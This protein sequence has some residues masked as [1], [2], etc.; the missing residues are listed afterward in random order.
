MNEIYIHLPSDVQP[1]R[2]PSNHASHYST[3]LD[4][5]I[6]LVGEW[7]VA[8]AEATYPKNVTMFQE[9]GIKFVELYKPSKCITGGKV[10]KKRVNIEGTVQNLCSLISELAPLLLTLSYE[11]D[12]FK[13]EVHHDYYLIH[14]PQR[15]QNLLGFPTCDFIK[16]TYYSKKFEGEG[17]F[18]NE[19]AL[20]KLVD[21]NCV[22]RDE[23]VIKEQG[24]SVK[25]V[26]E[27]RTLFRKKLAKTGIMIKVTN[28][29]ARLEKA[30]TSKT[31]DLAVV[32]GE[33]LCEALGFTTFQVVSHKGTYYADKRFVMQQ[34]A[35]SK[36]PWSLT[37]IKKRMGKDHLK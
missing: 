4:R 16:G 32:L 21:L 23:I 22:E 20:I 37:I 28:G 8:L 33:S 9:E 1:G 15:L 17:E 14:L 18:P 34:V 29:K 7:E 10:R 11:K 36:D 3:Q 12:M 35:K 31:D 30:S 26:H 5:P 13:L 6:D 2:F 25:T 19:N 24:V 27:M